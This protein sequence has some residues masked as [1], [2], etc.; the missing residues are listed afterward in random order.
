MATEISRWPLDGILGFLGALSLEAV[1]AGADFSDP[2]QQGRYLQLAI[3]DD[4]PSQLPTAY[5]MYVPG[6]VPIAGR[7]HLLVHEHN[8]AWLSHFA[9][10]YAKDGLITPELSYELRRR[11]CRLLLITSDFLFEGPS[12]TP[13]NLRESRVFALDCLRDAQFNGFFEHPRETLLKLARQWILMLEILPELLDIESDFMAATKGVSLQRYFEILAL[14]VTHIHH[15]MHPDHGR[16]LSRDR[17]Y[18]QVG[19][20]SDEIDLT[21]RRW[22]QTPEQYRRAFE[23]WN[24]ARPS[25]GHLLSY[26]F[27]TLRQRPLIEARAGEL[28]CPVVP[29]L[30]AKIVDE[31]YFILSEYLQGSRRQQFQDALGKAYERYAQ[32]LIDRL[33]AADTGGAWRVK[34]NPS[35][36]QDSELSDSY[37]Q[38]GDIGVCF[39][40]KGGRPSTNFLRGGPGDRILGPSE[41]VLTRIE[42]LEQVTLQKG[43]NQD[44][45]FLTRGMWQ[46]SL[47]G[48]SLLAWAEREMGA[49]PRQIFPIITHLAELRVDR[50][51]RS[52]YLDSLTQRAQLYPDKFWESP[53]WL[54]VSDLEALVSL[55]ERGEL[56]LKALLSKKVTQSDR[57]RFDIFLYDQF[58][59]I[60][61][62]RRLSETARALLE[63]AKV[64]FWPEAQKH[65]RG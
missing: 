42:N 15:V 18:V 46:Q 58:G 61:V 63:S 60:P 14:F 37:L 30:L 53:Q 47:A 35:I 2:R 19:T 32:K 21:L 20:R 7:H 65:G 10:L 33:A 64:S 6:R 44:S 8:I 56:D 9:L 5:A 13:S 43:L 3:F 45:G 17:L 27:V 11:V 51:A 31:P 59:R 38:K 50:L 40:H 23:A 57:R 34:H 1:Q 22:I 16:W 52:A 41:P 62:D 48:P 55:A 36:S 28:I 39:E 54:H 25:D 24:Q 4:F 12:T 29:F 26:D 49:Q